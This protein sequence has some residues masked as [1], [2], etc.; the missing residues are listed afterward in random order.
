VQHGNVQT[1]VSI[2]ADQ[3]IDYT[4]E[5]FT[6]VRARYD[7]VVDIA[8][9]RT[10]AETRRVLVPRG[11]LV[12]VGGPNE[13]HW[14]RPMSRSARM[15]LQSP[16]VGQ[17][18]VFFLA[19]QNKP[20]LAVPQKLLEDGRLRPVPDRTYPLSNVAH[21]IVYLEQGHATGKVAITV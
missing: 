8:G 13:G 2:G 18:L 7:I 1:A 11:V 15:A 5:D 3:V 6:A 10:L 9:N 16:L 12:A 14:L 17:H 21:A 19:C 20:G 4:K